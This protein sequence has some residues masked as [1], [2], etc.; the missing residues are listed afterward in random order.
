MASYRN[1]GFGLFLV[2]LT[3]TGESIGIC[4][5]VKRDSLD[6]PDIGFAFSPDSTGKGFGEESAKAIMEYSHNELG[7]K[8]IVAITSPVNERSQHLLRKIGL[9]VL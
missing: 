4:G 9:S 6:Y 7:L 1:H 5:L 3:S 8:K 2:C